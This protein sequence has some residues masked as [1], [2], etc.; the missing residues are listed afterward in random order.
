MLQ[1]SDGEWTG[2]CL[3]PPDA[4]IGRSIRAVAANAAVAALST[5]L[6]GPAARACIRHMPPVGCRGVRCRNGRGDA[7]VVGP[8]VDHPELDESGRAGP[9]ASRL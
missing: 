9:L 6:P 5:L 2:A 4:G 1:L 7:P 8:D 3:R